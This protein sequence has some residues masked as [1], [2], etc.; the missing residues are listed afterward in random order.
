MSPVRTLPKAS[1]SPWRSAGFKGLICTLV[2]PAISSLLFALVVGG[3]GGWAAGG[4]VRFLFG[5]K[6]KKSAPARR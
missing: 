2:K 5:P 3:L 1:F 4:I 6:I